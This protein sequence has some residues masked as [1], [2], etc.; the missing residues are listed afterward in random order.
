MDDCPFPQYCRQAVAVMR[1][2]SRPGQPADP[3]A[4]TIV[5]ERDLR[6]QGARVVSAWFGTHTDTG[7][8][9]MLH[10]QLKSGEKHHTAHYGPPEAA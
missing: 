4:V 1:R 6:M 3:C 8:R 7:E 10:V 5:L 9:K 2:L